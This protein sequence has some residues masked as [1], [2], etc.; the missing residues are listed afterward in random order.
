MHELKICIATCL[1]NEMSMSL[2]L[3]RV[4]Y[5]WTKTIKSTYTQRSG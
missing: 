4:E 2:T 3:T 5:Q 1:A